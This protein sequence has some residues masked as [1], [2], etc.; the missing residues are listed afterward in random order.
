MTVS[1]SGVEG[2]GFG[3][4]ERRFCQIWRKWPL[5]VASDFGRFFLTRSAV[6]PGQVVKNPE[7]TASIQVAE[8]E[9]KAALSK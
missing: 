5:T 6:R 4:V 3:F 2:G 8:T 1:L 7:L 9:L